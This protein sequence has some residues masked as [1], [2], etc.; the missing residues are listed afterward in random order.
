MP[1]TYT[2]LYIH[3]VFAVHGR[4]SLLRSEFREHVHKYITGIVEQRSHKLIA[5]NSVPDHMHLLI[6]YEPQQALSDLV[7]D[8]KS[9]S[10][11]YINEQGWMKTKFSW[12]TGYGAFSHS[13]SQIDA[14]VKYIANQETHHR[15]TD[16]R[17]EYLD[18]LEKYSVSYDP[19]YLFEWIE[20][21]PS[22]QE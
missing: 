9:H 20:D 12:Q 13:R 16:F 2:Q 3:I 21:L 22:P 8:I 4:D 17:R 18:M 7:R 10:A 6:G 1:N 14:V 15:K 11:K 5:I 19:K